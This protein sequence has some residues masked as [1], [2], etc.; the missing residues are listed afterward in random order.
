MSKKLLFYQF[1]SNSEPGIEKILKDSQKETNVLKELKN[2]KT[3]YSY[4]NIS[5]IAEVFC[6]PA[7]IWRFI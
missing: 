3:E 5:I 6:C 4:E 2:L 7:R 1:G